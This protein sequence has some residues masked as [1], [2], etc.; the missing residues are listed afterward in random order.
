MPKVGKSS[1]FISVRSAK[2][3]SASAA[4]V[5]YREAVADVFS[6]TGT[7]VVDVKQLRRSRDVAPVAKPTVKVE[8]PASAAV[9]HK[10]RLTLLKWQRMGRIERASDP[11]L[12]TSGHHHDIDVSLWIPA[13]AWYEDSYDDLM[14]ELSHL[15]MQHVTVS[16][17][18]YPYSGERAS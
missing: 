16:P 8:V 18:V 15:G 11:V 3:A 12:S 4:P 9:L 14:D 7:T 17:H 1:K 2:R 6:R 13:A 10:V 5:A